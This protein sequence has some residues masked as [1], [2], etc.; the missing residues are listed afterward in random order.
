MSGNPDSKAVV[1]EKGHD[2]SSKLKTFL[3]ILRKFV[4]VADIASV[5]FSLPAQLLEPTPNLEYWNY[6]DRPETFASIGTSDDELGRM[7]EV[8]RFWFTK[9]LKYIKGKPCKPYNSTLGEFFR[10]TGLQQAYWEVDT[11]PTPVLPPT[12]TNETASSTNENNGP[13]K[14]CFLTEQTSHHPPVSAFYIDCP[15]RGVSARGFDQLSAKFT[16]T[17]IRVGPGQHNLGI[18]VTLA[19]RDNEEYQLTHPLAHLSGLLR[20][21]L[22]ISVA[23]N[24]YITCPKTRIK[25]ILQYLEDGW[26]G[27]AQNRVEGVIFKYDPDND[28]KTKVK[29]VPSSDVLAR[30]S[31]CWREQVY[32]TLASPVSGSGSGSSTNSSTSSQDQQQQKHLLIDLAPL[33][34]AEKVV[35]PEEVQLGNESR[36]FWSGV[37]RSILDKQYSQ[38]TKLKQEIE[39]R[40][41]TKAANREAANERWKPRFFTDATTP[42]GKPALTDDGKQVL[43]ALYRGDFELEE[44]KVL[45][46]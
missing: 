39:E 4:G 36:K 41:R 38:A 10:L 25:V 42:L 26:V 16:G 23:D 45:G 40:Q 6:L 18:F 7:L 8:L 3:S 27:R 15:E 11:A 21:S 19:K 30:I 43:E 32:F 1:A 24:C 31:G 20:G 37:T 22:Y 5:R 17:S 33:F 9:D 2:D 44:S 35:P 46:A 13:A 14:V 12:T 29:D 28:N 34:P